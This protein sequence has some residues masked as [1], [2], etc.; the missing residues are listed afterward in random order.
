MV[1]HY[2][3]LASNV[4]F[5]LGRYMSKSKTTGNLLIL[6]NRLYQLRLRAFKEGNT[7]E[8]KKEINAVRDLIAQ[9]NQKTIKEKKEGKSL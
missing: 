7:E 3:L 6:R 9:E 5:L 4:V 2:L 8:I 1:P